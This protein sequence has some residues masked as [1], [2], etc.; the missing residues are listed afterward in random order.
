MRVKTAI[1]GAKGAIMHLWLC[2]AAYIGF[3]SGWRLV[4]T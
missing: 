3:I 2:V 4:V 1:F